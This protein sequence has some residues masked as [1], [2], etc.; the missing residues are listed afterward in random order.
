MNICFLVERELKTN[1][2][3]CPRAELH[4]EGSD[5]LTEGSFANGFQSL[6]WTKKKRVVPKVLVAVGKASII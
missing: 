1:P 6:Q 5:L 4:D 2:L 3:G